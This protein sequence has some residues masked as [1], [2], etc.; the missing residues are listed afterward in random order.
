MQDS[1]KFV[2]AANARIEDL[3]EKNEIEEKRLGTK[4]NVSLLDQSEPWEWIKD[5]ENVSLMP[6]EDDGENAT[7]GFEDGSKAQWVNTKRM[8]C[9]IED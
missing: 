1:K 5:A 4:L 8:Y 2:L 6:L 7:W 3:N 9:V